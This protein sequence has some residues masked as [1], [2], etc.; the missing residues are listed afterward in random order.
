MYI[1][2]FRNNE[3]IKWA[4]VRVDEIGEGTLTFRTGANYA[5][6]TACQGDV[7]EVY[8]GGEIPK[9]FDG[10]P[11]AIERL[12]RGEMYL[13]TEKRFAEGDR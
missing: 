7:L 5:P 3:T 8:A 2:R 1:L 13:E 12:Y 11:D 9:V 10:D 4:H 6:I